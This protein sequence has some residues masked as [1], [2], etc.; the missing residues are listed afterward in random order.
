MSTDSSSVDDALWN[1]FV[2]ETLDFLPSDLIFKQR[3]AAGLSV[4]YFKPLDIIFF[5]IRDACP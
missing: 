5:R 1:S 3:G 2:I 4:R